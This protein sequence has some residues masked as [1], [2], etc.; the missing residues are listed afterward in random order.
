MI[1]TACWSDWTLVHF[2]CIICSSWIFAETDYMD[3]FF[4]DCLDMLI[5]WSDRS[6][7]SD[8][9]S[10]KIDCSSVRSD[11]KEPD[12]VVNSTVNSEIQIKILSIELS[13][14]SVV[15]DVEDWLSYFLMFDEAVAVVCL[16]EDSSDKDSKS[17]TRMSFQSSYW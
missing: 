10:A 12:F 9:S 4:N 17:E 8:W 6:V 2:F 7:W 5:R 16:C 1:L 3:V 15:S 11:E 13:V 14:E